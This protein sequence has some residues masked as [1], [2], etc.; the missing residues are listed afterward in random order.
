MSAELESLPLSALQHFAF[1]PRQ[2]ALIHIERQWV[3]NRLTAEGR[4]LHDKAHDAGNENRRD[5][6]IARALPLQSTMLR[7]HGVADIVE[8]HRQAGGS[9]QPF[10]IE[11]KRGRPKPDSI[12]TVQLCAQAICLE[13]MLGQS[14][15]AGAIYYGT[16]HRRHDVVFDTAL[17]AETTR[18]SI[19]T[20]ALIAAGRTPSPRF[21]PKC[22]SCS[23]LDL[24]RPEA[25]THSAS[26]HLARLMNPHD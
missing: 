12:D 15:P 3:E 19:A 8:F 21:M 13:E 1:C 25:V 11:Y 4:V 7:L 17:R 10:P 16:T 18:L 9:W 26:Q 23:F 24:C 22:R 14:I 6:R 2:C 20:H 5:I